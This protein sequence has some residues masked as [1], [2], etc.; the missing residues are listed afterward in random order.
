MFLVQPEDRSWCIGFTHTVET[1]MRGEISCRLQ[2]I[3]ILQI[4]SERILGLEVLSSDN[5][6]DSLD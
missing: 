1:R 3:Y 6:M 4:P 2:Y 5:V